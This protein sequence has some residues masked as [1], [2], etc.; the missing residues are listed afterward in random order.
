MSPMYWWGTEKEAAGGVN[1]LG[2]GLERWEF[3]DVYKEGGQ[4]GAF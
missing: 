1:G 2:L 3:I 4:E